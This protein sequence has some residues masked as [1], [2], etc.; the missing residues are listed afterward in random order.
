MKRPSN[1]SRLLVYA[2]PYRYL[3]FASWILSAVSAL[4]ALLPFLY[5]WKILQE[6]LATAPAFNAAQE[7]ARNGWLAVLSAALA[8]LIYVTALLCSHLS[9][10]RIASNIRS[11]A[12]RQIVALPMSALERFGSGRLRKI[13]DESS[14]ATETYLAHQLPD[15]AGAIATP[16]GLV[17]LLLA[18]DWRLGLLSLVPAT[19]AFFIL[20]H[21]TGAQMQQ[22]MQEYQNALERMSNEAV[23]YIR[24]MPVVKTFGQ[25]IFSCKRFKAAIDNY[26]IWVVSYTRSLRLPMLFY[27]TAV[28]SVF[29][30]L[31]AAGLYAAQRGD[32]SDAFLLN[33]LFYIIISLAISIA[34]TRIMFLSEN[35]MT[36]E[37]A[38]ARIDS[39]FDVHPLPEA[40]CSIRP[41]DASVKLPNATYSYGDGKSALRDVSLR[42]EPGQTARWLDLPAAAR[43]RW[44]ARSLVS[45]TCSRAACESA[46]RTYETFPKKI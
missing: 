10:F 35:A 19:L 14:A 5:I 31:I 43:L 18:F 36:I 12:M 33:L 39:I 26:G 40:A 41:Q 15:K 2:G 34:L 23:E 27:T 45:S 29:A 4:T 46:A 7:L 30:F 32:V 38:L 21:M 1:L 25:T 9:A 28:N 17:L 44:P 20:L 8:L 16:C 6:I 42:I 13:V 3:T 11:Q 22:K 37:D 24:G